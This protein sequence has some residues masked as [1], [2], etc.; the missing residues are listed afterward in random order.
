MWPYSIKIS[1]GKV[2]LVFTIIGWETRA[3]KGLYAV[4]L[5][6]L[7]A[8]TVVCTTGLSYETPL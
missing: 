4:E 7:H 5:E 8:I 2:R 6:D 1:K 3:L